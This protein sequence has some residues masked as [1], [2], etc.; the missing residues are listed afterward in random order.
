MRILWLDDQ[1]DLQLEFVEGLRREGHEVS[2][3]W[4]EQTAV[5][6]LESEPTPDLFIQDL[7][8][9]PENAQ[10]SWLPSRVVSVS[11][12]DSGWSFYRDVL[13]LGFPQLPVVIVSWE[14]HIQKNRRTAEDFNVTILQKGSN[15]LKSLLDT[16]SEML[17]AQRTILSSQQVPSIIRLDF[18]KVNA[19]LIR[20]LAK[21]PNDIDCLTWSGFEELVG[22]LL[23][24]SGYEV[25][26]TKLTRD[27]GVDIW[28]LQRSDL[29]TTLYAI[30]AKKYNRSRI[31]GPE[32]VRAIYGVADLAGAS[33][34]IIVTTAT[35]GPAAQQLAS[36]YRYRI[37]LK[38]FEDITKWIK[39][40]GNSA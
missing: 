31:I 17:N 7:H 21:H 24:E 34:G 15:L 32:P 18:E 10:L 38:D 25:T 40:V 29:G 27:G 2:Q 35:F 3:V 1:P 20:H 5:E 16:T 39:R 19:T 22:V 11:E 23:K 36:Q 26:H 4:S 33:A 8:R 6:Y 30:D 28:A 14:A 12:A 37:S 9:R 13:F